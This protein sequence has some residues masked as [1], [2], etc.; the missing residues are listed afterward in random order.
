MVNKLRKLRA[1]YIEWN[2]HCTYFGWK[3]HEHE[4]P[5]FTVRTLGWLVQEDKDKVVVSASWTYL[6]DVADPTII[7]KSDITKMVEIELPKL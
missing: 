6:D 4:F 7:L 1:V 3:D 2:D 5:I